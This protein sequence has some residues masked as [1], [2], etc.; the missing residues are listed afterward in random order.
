M[1]PLF[2]KF[3]EGLENSVRAGIDG[4]GRSETPAD[5]A[6]LVNYEKGAFA[7]SVFMAVCAVFAGDVALGLKIRQEREM[8]VTIFG[9]FF[10]TPDAVDGDAEK[11]GAV[12]FEFRE[13][14]VVEGHLIAADR[15][16]VGGIEGENHGISAQLAESE[17]LIGRDVEREI[18]GF[19]SGS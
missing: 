4:D 17:L 12:F 11:F 1:T 18:R 7:E 13:D 16:E 8:E 19:C 15:T 5:C 10:V 14:F 9:E 6:V 3:F 2:R